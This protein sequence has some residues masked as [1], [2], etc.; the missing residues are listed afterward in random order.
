MI[1]VGALKPNGIIDN[2]GL[3]LLGFIMLLMSI[4]PL[5]SRGAFTKIILSDTGITVKYS[6]KRKKFIDWLRGRPKV[7]NR[8]KRYVGSFENK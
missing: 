7:K 8:G 2:R 5:L 1:V 6:K 4:I 3:I